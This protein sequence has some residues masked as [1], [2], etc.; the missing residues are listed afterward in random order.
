MKPRVFIGSSKEGLSIAKHVEHK[1]SPE[2]ECYLWT[3][4]IFKFN[5]SSLESLLQ[6]ASLFDFGILVATGDDFATV[7]KMPFEVPRDNVIFE[8]GLFLGRL[9][10]SRAFIIQEENAKLPSDL[11]GVTV[12][13]FKRADPIESSDSLNAEIDKIAVEINRKISLGH[14]GLLPSTALAIGYYHNFVE[15]ICRSLYEKKEFKVDDKVFKKFELHIVLPNA[16]DSDIK[17]RA[18]IYS[19]Q[20]ELKQI[21]IETYGR[22]YPVYVAFD[23]SEP[24]ILK[25][26]DMPTTLNGLDKAIELY[27]KKGH[28]G[29]SDQHHLLEERELRNFGAVLQSLAENDAFCNSVIK[30]VVQD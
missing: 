21:S 7:R 5:E 14:L 11:Y 25:I 24:E 8:F 2:C 23:D 13:R 27:V 29:K 16:L 18:S 20:K 6:E 28:V 30:I 3:A 17:K 15:L 1:L 12:P 26:Y 4:D 22:D 9:G 10:S 19:R